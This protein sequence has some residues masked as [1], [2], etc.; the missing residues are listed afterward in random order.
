MEGA[1][2]PQPLPARAGTVGLGTVAFALLI[3]PSAGLFVGLVG[4]LR[5]R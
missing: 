4:S 5:P 3:G 2:G 1:L